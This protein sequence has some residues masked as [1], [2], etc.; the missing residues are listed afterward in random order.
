VLLTRRRAARRGDDRGA[1]AAVAA[2]FF[3]S[4]VALGICALVVDVGLIYAQHKQLQTGADAAAVE[5]ARVCATSA[6]ACGAPESDAAAAAYARVNVLDG[7][8]TAVV[9]GRGGGLS[10]CPAPSDA[11]C[12]GAAPEAGVYAEVRTSILT[13]DGSTLLPPVFAQ[14]VVDDYDGAAVTA[15]ARVTWGSPAAARTLAL[16]I[17]T[18]DWKRMAG[19]GLPSTE[20]AVALYTDSD[21][22]A[23]GRGGTGAADPGGFRWVAGPDS[24]CRT[25]ASTSTPLRATLPDERPNGCLDVLESLIATPGQAVAV[26]IFAKV[27]DAGDGGFAYAVQ[28]VAAFVVTG[29]QLPDSVVPSPNLSSCGPGVSTCV[30]GFFTRA[31]VP[32]GGTVGG[33][34]LGAQITALIG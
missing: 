20:Q 19:G 21:P 29:W 13:A 7:A 34:D 3:G 30:Y 23:C 18:C 32:G 2:V 6:V 8:A 26:P 4:G 22:A 9:C 24:T 5:V 15:C 14:A 10:E 1:V 31:V 33:P 25:S 17:S 28:G 27:T 16:T 12:T 11:T